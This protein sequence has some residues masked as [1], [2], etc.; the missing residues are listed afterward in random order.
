L[1]SGSWRVGVGVV[2]G[3]RRRSAGTEVARPPGLRRA[4]F[5]K[6]RGG[7]FSYLAETTGTCTSGLAHLDSPLF[8]MKLH[9][10]GKSYLT[11]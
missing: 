1:L 5:R 2:G 10:P 8:S 11:H 3:E 9:S 7:L 6:E 4:T